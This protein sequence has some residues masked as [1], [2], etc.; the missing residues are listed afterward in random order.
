[1]VG[2]KFQCN[3]FFYH[4]VY[5]VPCYFGF[6]GINRFGGG[7]PLQKIQF[8]N[9]HGTMFFSRSSTD[10][11]NVSIELMQGFTIECINGVRFE[12]RKGICPRTHTP[13]HTKTE[14][15]K[16]SKTIRVFCLK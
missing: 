15:E 12:M 13:K 3:E 11:T 9:I 14:E 6:T 1:M 4:V 16:M 8:D 7:L 2:G 10:L 5:S